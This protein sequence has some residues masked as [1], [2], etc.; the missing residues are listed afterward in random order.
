[1]ASHPPSHLS[2]AHAPSQSPSTLRAPS[3]FSPIASRRDPAAEPSRGW[4]SSGASNVPRRTPNGYVSS[5]PEGGS[6]RDS[7]ELPRIATALG[8]EGGSAAI[9]ARRRQSSSFK[10]LSTGSLVSKSPFRQ[11]A[12]AAGPPPPLPTS[13]AATNSIYGVSRLP[14]STRIGGPSGSPTVERRVSGSR[15]VS[16]EVEV[17]KE[18]LRESEAEAP[19]KHENSAGTT[20]STFTKPPSS[21]SIPFRPVR[22]HAASP[23]ISRDS[24]FPPPSSG[25]S[26]RPT[27]PQSALQGSS[28]MDDPPRR[29]SSSYAAV[30]KNG[31]VSSSPFMSRG[32]PTVPGSLE[33]PSPPLHETPSPSLPSDSPSFDPEPAEEHKINGPMGLGIRPGGAPLPERHFA[34]A[35]AP[36]PSTPPHEHQRSNSYSS[37][38][39]SALSPSR[40]W[41]M[42]PRPLEED[43]ITSEDLGRTLRRQP[44][45]KTVTWAATE[46]VLEFEVDDEERRRSG[47]SE[48]SESS[49]IGDSEDGEEWRDGENSLE[50]EGDRSLGFE[51]DDA[52]ESLGYEE[53]GSVEMHHFGDESEDDHEGSAVSTA[54]STVED[55]M[56]EIDAFMGDVFSPSLVTDDD[57]V[58]GRTNGDL[59]LASLSKNLPQLP[60]AASSPAA[61]K[62]GSSGPQSAFS[63][64]STGAQSDSDSDNDDVNSE[65]SYTDEEEV[66]LQAARAKRISEAMMEAERA[67]PLWIP[68]PAPHLA[69]S[70]SAYSL[71]DLPEGSPFLG[72]EDTGTSSS[73]VTFDLGDE[74]PSSVGATVAPVQPL[75]TQVHAIPLQSTPTKNVPLPAPNALEVSPILSAFADASP[76]PL[77][78]SRHASIVDFELSTLSSG[79]S[80]FANMRGSLR[81]ASKLREG[82]DRLD[83]KLRQHQA[84]LSTPSESTNSDS[85]DD[86]VPRNLDLFPHPPPKASPPL[87]SPPPS[88]APRI[89]ETPKEQVRAI[90]A[91]PALKVTEATV[92]T[93]MLPTI[94]GGPKGTRVEV[95]ARLTAQ[96][97]DEME[98]PLDRLR[99]EVGGD[100]W[101]EGDSIE[102]FLEDLPT[103][104]G[105]S[106]LLRRRSLSTG[107]IASK[108]SFVDLGTARW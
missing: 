79:A 53:G 108:V 16:G 12:A 80:K 61:T 101:K 47:A 13:A 42:G 8:A 104:P 14:Q 55:M 50:E 25:A 65:S 18:N 75:F 84:I 91:R 1:M 3:S 77:H 20:D 106:G 15:K 21:P 100:E 39:S 90:Q 11:G 52:N 78:L 29:Q 9:N 46:E 99:K 45:S 83:E 26:F 74:P 95:G 87:Q 51:V 92:S 57:A 27:R 38:P 70:T 66:V 40:R 68:T 24:G 33:H 60:L 85:T 107:D 48:R 71:P 76:P 67:A 62:Q 89:V 37:S 72:F 94:A 54:S 32:V 36:P 23:S 63:I 7:P 56:G 43:E 81:G 28:N 17:V 44:S 73:V 22:S 82:R 96:V 10:T 31:L 97:V 93:T 41:M 64:S 2:T 58:F 103:L 88:Q 30:R 86:F 34:G 105:G 6:G 102:S 19:A 59:D 4:T 35:S 49:S 98:S 69:P 5:E